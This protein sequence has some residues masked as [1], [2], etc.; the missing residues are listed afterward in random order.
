MTVSIKTLGI[1][2]FS[3]VL[4]ACTHRGSP[5]S[6]DFQTERLLG[7][8]TAHNIAAQSIRPVDLPNSN[9]LTGQS[10]TRAVTAITRLNTREPVE[11]S[12][13]SASGISSTAD[14]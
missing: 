9:G 6:H 3:V 12:D 8:A 1:L 11:F 4:T 2:V 7:G 10:G 5:V 13:V 14:E